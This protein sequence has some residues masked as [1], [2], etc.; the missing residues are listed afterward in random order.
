MT[1]GSI[2]IID[3]IWFYFIL[4]ILLFELVICSLD[5]MNG[6]Q[7]FFENPVVLHSTMCNRGCGWF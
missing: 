1:F 2:H 4:F 5:I 7:G 3:I 6:D